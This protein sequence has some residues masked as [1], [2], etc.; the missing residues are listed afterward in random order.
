MALKPGQLKCIN[1]LDKPIVV[2]AGAGSGKTFTLTKRIVNALETHYVDD[3]GQV[4]AITFTNNAAAELK[5][6]VKSALRAC[7]MVE[8]SLKADDA[9]ISTIHGMCARILRA[10]AVELDIDPAFK[11]AE[12]AE[13]DRFLDEAI[14]ELRETRD[15]VASL[16]EERQRANAA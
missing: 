4:C 8:Q 3:I 14:D 15:G 5:S 7:G 11:M 16:V 12:G 2:A 10:H 9:W 1:T 13:V 6:R